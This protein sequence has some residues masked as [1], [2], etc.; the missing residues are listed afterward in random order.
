MVRQRRHPHRPPTG[1]R[2]RRRRSRD[3][4]ASAQPADESVPHLQA[5]AEPVDEQE[6]RSLTGASDAEAVAGQT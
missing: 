1:G 5:G 3:H 2:Y 6:R 4:L